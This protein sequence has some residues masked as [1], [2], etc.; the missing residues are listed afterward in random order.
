MKNTNDVKMNMFLNDLESKIDKNFFVNKEELTYYLELK[1][2]EFQDKGNFNHEIL[3]LLNKFDKNNAS[4]DK[5]EGL[6]EYRKEDGTTGVTYKKDDS[7][8][9]IDNVSNIKKEIDKDQNKSFSG[10]LKNKTLE[11]SMDTL[12]KFVYD[13]EDLSKNTSIQNLDS[14]EIK[15]L[16]YYNDLNNLNLIFTES[17]LAIDKNGNTLEA[18]MDIYGNFT[19][20]KLSQ[21]TFNENQKYN[22]TRTLLYKI[23]KDDIEN[24]NN[25]ENILLNERILDY[26][27]NN[28]ED[29]EYILEDP[30]LNLTEQQKN[31]YRNALSLDIENL[32]NKTSITNEKAKQ[33]VY[34]PHH[35]PIVENA[36]VSTII[37]SLTTL[38]FGLICF[39]YF[40]MNI[41]K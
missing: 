12:T 16:K 29:Y 23:D 34:K 19:I 39:T 32:N 35:K 41:N 10:N 22:V 20:Y 36:F 31:E 3:Q 7:L 5:Y 21:S 6:T 33:Y 1:G 40:I 28:I 37:L 9:N 2:K 38:S 8:V 26:L 4:L 27:K 13:E 14:K 11:E 18:I 24:Y 25:K 15:A 30:T 17:G